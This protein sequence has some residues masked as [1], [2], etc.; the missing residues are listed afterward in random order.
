MHSFVF[1]DGYFKSL[2]SEAILGTRIYFHPNFTFYQYFL[3]F[4]YHVLSRSTTCEK[5][6]IPSILYWI[7]RFFLF[8]NM[9]ICT[10]TLQISK[11]LSVRLI[12]GKKFRIKYWNPV[13]TERIRKVWYLY[14][15][16]FW[17]LLPMCNFIKGDWVLGYISTQIP[18]FSNISLFPKVMI[19]KLIG[20]SWSNSCSKFPILDIKFLLVLRFFRLLLS[21]LNLW[22]GSWAVGYF[23]NSNFKFF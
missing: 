18:H 16:V 1:F 5:T 4:K 3:I 17:L 6:R 12:L 10:K 7:S 19:P 22:K 9:W 21:K 15:R 23:S 20:N 2:N 13:K 14:L 8:L 11:I